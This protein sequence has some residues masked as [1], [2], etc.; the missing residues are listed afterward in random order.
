MLVPR[1]NEW[2]RPEISVCR[3]LMSFLTKSAGRPE[4]AYQLSLV[5]DGVS[6]KY[7]PGPTNIP[8]QSEVTRPMDS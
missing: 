2:Q 7:M 3:I 6:F 8:D 4:A 5:V 1:P